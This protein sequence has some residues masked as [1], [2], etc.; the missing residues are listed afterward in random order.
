MKEII[1][2][3]FEIFL[4]EEVLEHLSAVLIENSYSKVFVLMDTNTKRFCWPMLSPY[5]VNFSPIVIPEGEASKSLVQAEKI[6]ETLQKNMADRQAVLINLGG[7]VISDIGGFCAATYKRGIDFINVPTS[8][9][10][11]VDAA[12]G[13]KLGIDFLSFKN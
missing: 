2:K 1:Q 3:D 9:L 5:L 12:I 11:M 6:W 4:G 10:G 7:G 8:L 13:G